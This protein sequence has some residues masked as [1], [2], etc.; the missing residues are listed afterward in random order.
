M[1]GLSAN[2]TA[3]NEI[4]R[5]RSDMTGTAGNIFEMFQITSGLILGLRP[6]NES[7]RY[8]SNAASQWLGTNLES[9]L[10]PPC[11]HLHLFDGIPVC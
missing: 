7:R 5:H 2:N 9:A 3:E 8:K 11:H 6:A 4:F 10:S 1:A